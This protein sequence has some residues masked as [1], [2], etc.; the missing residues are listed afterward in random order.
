MSGWMPKNAWIAQKKLEN[1]RKSWLKVNPDLPEECG[2]YVLTRTDENGMR[3]AYVGQAKKILTRLAQHSVGYKEHIDRSIKTHKLYS[4][5]NP[6]GWNVDYFLCLQSELNEYE[7]RFVL[8]YASKGYQ[9]RNKTSGGQDKGKYGIAEQKPSKGYY[10][11]LKQGY[12]N[13]RRDVKEFF[14]NYLRYLPK[15]KEECFKKDGTLKMIYTKKY[16]EFRDWLEE[17]SND[18]KEN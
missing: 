14:D 13:A 18:E 6:Y 11:G 15:N 17:K 2:I 16:I 12:I 4:V 7:R 5:Q 3:Y 1:Y 8:E 9:L 10:D